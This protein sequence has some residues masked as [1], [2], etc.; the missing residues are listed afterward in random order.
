MCVSHSYHLALRLHNNN[1]LSSIINIA[2]K[3]FHTNLLYLFCYKV[4]FRWVETSY[5][6]VS[7][8]PLG[9]SPVEIS[10]CS[11][12]G[13]IVQLMFHLAA[14]S[15][16]SIEVSSTCCPRDLSVRTKHSQWRPAALLSS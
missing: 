8:L 12:L 7:L 3:L 13:V 4:P 5:H 15:S 6:C 9:N 14:T 1:Y 16:R 10:S 2:N 11:Y